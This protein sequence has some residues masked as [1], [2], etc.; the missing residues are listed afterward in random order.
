MPRHLH[1]HHPPARARRVPA[2]Y[3]PPHRLP[4]SPYE[5]GG[6]DGTRPRQH[7]LHYP[8]PARARRVPTTPPPSH[9]P[10]RTR[11]VQRDQATSPHL[12]HP[13]HPTPSH[14]PIRTRRVQRDQATSPPPPPP[15]RSSAEGPGHLCTTPPH[16]RLPI[17]TRRV[18]ATSAPPHRLPAS[19]YERERSDVTRPR[20]PTFTTLPLERRGS[21]RPMHHPTAFPPF[22]TNAEGPT[23]PGRVTP[24]P[25][26]AARVRRVSATSAPPHRLPG[27]LYE[28]GGSHRTRPRHHHLHHPPARVRIVPATC[29]PPLPP[30]RLS[31]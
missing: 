9:R 13:R 24:P 1:L 4:T 3:A 25:P 20:H 16:S 21:R 28:R 31:I 11:R 15:S 5:R 8:P 18:P 23:G 17:R 19:P 22:Y 10:I 7:L 30:T 2:T 6:S 29:S 26:L 12:Y 14:R 27:S